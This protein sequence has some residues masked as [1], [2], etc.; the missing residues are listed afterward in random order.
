M[1]SLG[2]QNSKVS[3]SKTRSNT[4][5]LGLYF[6][7]CIHYIF[8]LFILELVSGKPPAHAP[9]PTSTRS[10]NRAKAALNFSSVIASL[11]SAEPG[12]VEH[13]GRGTLHTRITQRG[14]L[15]YRCSLRLS[16][17]GW[18]VR[19]CI[20]AMQNKPCRCPCPTDEGLST[21]S[22]HSRSI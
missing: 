8:S 14:S 3:L 17:H 10:L 2:F 9:C 5:S 16:V 7:E 1:R 12:V 15:R 20:Q 13:G 21:R 22:R 11:A 4:N 18:G 6:E 19:S